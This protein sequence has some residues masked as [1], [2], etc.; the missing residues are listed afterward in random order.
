MAVFPVGNRA[1]IKPQCVSEL[2]LRDAQGRSQSFDV[3]LVFHI[4]IM[5]YS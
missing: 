2:G 1:L 5:I 4:G 3:D